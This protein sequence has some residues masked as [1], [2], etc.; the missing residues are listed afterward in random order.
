MYFNVFAPMHASIFELY[1]IKKM[2][3]VDIYDEKIIL[4]TW[5]GGD[6]SDI[7]NFFTN[8]STKLWIL[9]EDP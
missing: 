1:T 8:S 4:Q 5:G 7:C 6:I 3:A 9:T 2:K